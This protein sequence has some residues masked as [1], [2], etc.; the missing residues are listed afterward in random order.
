MSPKAGH[1]PRRLLKTAVVLG[2]LA[3]AAVSL[4]DRLPTLHEVLD[5]LRSAD[6]VWL[7]IAAGA[8]LVSIGMFARQQ[9]RLLFAFGVRMSR[10]RALALSYTRSAIAISVPAGS[11][12]SAAFAFRQFRAEGAGR[13]T[14]ATV[15]VLALLVSTTSLLGLFVTGALATGVVRLGEAW[16]DEPGFAGGTAMLTLGLL[17][18]IG[19]LAAR[20]GYQ[21]RQ[22]ADHP[23]VGWLDRQRARWPR[24][25][26]LLDPVAEAVRSSREVAARHWG[27]AF[28]AAVANWLAELLCLFAAAQ[29]F[30]LPLNIVTL[31][32]IYLTVQVVRQVPLTP[33]GI[34]VIEISLLAGLVAAGAGEA[35]AAATVLVYRLLSCWLLIPAGLLAWWLVLRRPPRSAD[36]P[37]E[38]LPDVLPEIGR[39]GLVT[40]QMPEQR[41][42]EQAVEQRVGHAGRHGGD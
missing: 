4:R 7:M 13:R 33:G 17:A 12:V 26:T 22:R 40:G 15:M 36:E 42:V 39:G 23:R 34:G 3:V 37:V 19:L 21:V 30:D 9:R 10:H 14:A 2:L 5:A 27:L 32:A 28:G 35:A 29:A 1:R 18:F 25:A 8:E 38:D 16:Q 6:P 31:G 20:T 11:A 41:P 24:L